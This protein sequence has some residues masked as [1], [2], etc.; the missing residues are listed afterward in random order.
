M[1]ID[2]NQ[3][4][5]DTADLQC[6]IDLALQG[7]AKPVAEILPD[8]HTRFHPILPDQ[9]RPPRFVHVRW[10]ERRWEQDLVRFSLRRES[11]MRLAKPDVIWA[12]FPAYAIGQI[13]QEVQTLPPDFSLR[14]L[15]SLL[16]LVKARSAADT[17]RI[18][19]Q[20]VEVRIRVHKPKRS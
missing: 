17:R 14:L 18:T 10:L 20:V 13:G 1:K 11:T 7:T 8:G 5:Y 4:W 19:E 15:K 9:S 2:T 16:S 12:Q 3:T 6:I